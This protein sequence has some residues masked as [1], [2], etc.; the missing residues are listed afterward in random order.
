MG[1]SGTSDVS[2]NI[3]QCW[4]ECAVDEEKRSLPMVLYCSIREIVINN[5][6][7]IHIVQILRDKRDGKLLFKR[8]PLSRK[9]NPVELSHEWV[10]TD[11]KYQEPEF[12]SIFFDELLKKH[13]EVP[14]RRTNKHE[15]KP[16]N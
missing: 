13:F 5:G 15:K 16:S 14:P 8:K 11:L 2:I 3:V 1:N 6:W 4:H 9:P 10:L 12:Y 7:N